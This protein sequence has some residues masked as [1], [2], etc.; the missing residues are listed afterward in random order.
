[1]GDIHINKQE[2][3]SSFQHV[4]KKDA[5][6]ILSYYL[7]CKKSFQVIK[8]YEY[9]YILITQPFVFEQFLVQHVQDA[10]IQLDAMTF[11]QLF[12]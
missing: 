5:Y 7:Y 9:F 1:M 4:K 11:F 3:F 10:A 8:S 2:I 6:I 12:Q